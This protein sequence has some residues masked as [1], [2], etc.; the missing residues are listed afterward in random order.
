MP[1]L[2]KL[3]KITYLQAFA[4]VILARL[5]FGSFGHGQQYH[6]HPHPHRYYQHYLHGHEYRNRNLRDWKCYDL[7]WREEGKAAFDNYM[8]KMEHQDKE[9]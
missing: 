6:H 2:F 4:L 9:S 3:G 5:I 8:T 1:S 7:W